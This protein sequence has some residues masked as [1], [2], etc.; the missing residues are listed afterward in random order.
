M[1]S[2]ELGLYKDQPSQLTWECQDESSGVAEAV[3]KA[4]APLDD[5]GEVDRDAVHR[6]QELGEHQVDQDQV[7]GRPDLKR[8]SQD[9]KLAISNNLPKRPWSCG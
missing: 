5:A 8:V 4:V 9:C 2:K 6:D 7:E 1:A 3:A